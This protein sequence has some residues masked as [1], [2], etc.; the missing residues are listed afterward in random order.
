MP[1][2]AGQEFLT[3]TPTIRFEDINDAW[4]AYMCEFDLFLRDGSASRRTSRRT[5][6]QV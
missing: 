2:S 3:L 1:A 5:S 6:S 4:R